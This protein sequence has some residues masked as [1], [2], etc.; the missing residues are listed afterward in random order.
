[1]NTHIH[2]KRKRARHVLDE[3]ALVRLARRALE[4]HEHVAPVALALSQLVLAAELSTSAHTV[5]SLRRLPH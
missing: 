4:E 5:Y 1:M 3:L 2:P